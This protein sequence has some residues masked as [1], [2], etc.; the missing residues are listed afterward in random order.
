MTIERCACVTIGDLE[1][2][3]GI[4]RDHESRWSFWRAYT[5]SPSDPITEGAAEL[6]HRIETRL[7]GF[8]MPTDP[9]SM[10]AR[11]HG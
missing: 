3:A 11:R 1:S 5:T 9:P 2:A 4:G 8:R 6:R 10:K 7:S